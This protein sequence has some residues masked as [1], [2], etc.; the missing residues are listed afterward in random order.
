MPSRAHTEMVDK[1]MASFEDGQAPEQ[2]V[3]RGD[4]SVCRSVNWWKESLP[5]P[6][7]TSSRKSLQGNNLVPE[8]PPHQ[9]GALDVGGEEIGLTVKHRVEPASRVRTRSVFHNGIYAISCFRPR[10]PAR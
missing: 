3:L 7:M 6:R 1:L 4:G 5:F 10:H 2:S 8:E 9:D